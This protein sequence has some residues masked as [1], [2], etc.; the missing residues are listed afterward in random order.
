MPFKYN[1]KLVIRDRKQ[2]E[3]LF[4]HRLD[5]F[6]STRTKNITFTNH[7]NTILLILGK[8]NRSKNTLDLHLYDATEAT[9]LP[10][11]DISLVI[12]FDNMGSIELVTKMDLDE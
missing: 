5:L 7:T 9:N 10:D 1:D 11:Y 4:K 2:M 6:D 8:F 3:D 12:R